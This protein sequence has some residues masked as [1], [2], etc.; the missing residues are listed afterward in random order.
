VVEEP[1][2]AKKVVFALVPVSNNFQPAGN[3]DDVPDGTSVLKFCVYAVVVLV[4]FTCANICKQQNKGS[5]KIALLVKEVKS[6]IG[7]FL[8]KE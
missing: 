4:I 5:E 8:V 2:P 6:F 1:V 7:K 3:T